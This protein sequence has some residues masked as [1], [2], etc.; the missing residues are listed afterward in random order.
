[1]VNNRGSA[2]RDIS[3]RGY[4][5]NTKLLK[6]IQCTQPLVSSLRHTHEHKVF[7]FLPFSFLPL[8]CECER[9]MS[10]VWRFGWCLLKVACWFAVLFSLS[11]PCA[12]CLCSFVNARGVCS[13]LLWC[14]WLPFPGQYFYFQEVLPVLAAKHCMMQATAELHQSALA[15]QKKRF[16]E[17]IARLQVGAVGKII[18]PWFLHGLPNE[19]IASV[20]I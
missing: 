2:S 13:W 11:A 5:E 20:L 9:C 4:D 10:V 16:G 12:V 3:S 14:L 19:I 6:Q 1:M 7:Q 8:I 15:K 18:K 17:E